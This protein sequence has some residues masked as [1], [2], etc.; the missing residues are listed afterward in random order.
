M[1]RRTG[2]APILRSCRGGRAAAR[3][4]PASRSSA[5]ADR[6]IKRTLARLRTEISQVD[7]K[8]IRDL[9]ERMKWVQ[10]IGR[11]KQQH[12]IPV[13]QI[14]RWENLLLDHI[15]KAQEVGLDPDF[16]KDVF[17]I[18]HAQAVKRQL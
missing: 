18:I 13:L 8:I 16:I 1:R 3:R 14:N 17:E 6:E 15:A 12:N 7:A 11:L 9:A 5:I 2:S 4:R 10:E